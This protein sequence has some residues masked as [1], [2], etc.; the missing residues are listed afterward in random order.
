M[1]IVMI[2]CVVSIT[3]YL[4][5]NLSNTSI[6]NYIINH[7]HRPHRKTHGGSSYSRTTLYTWDKLAR[8]T[9]NNITLQ[10]LDVASG[11]IIASFH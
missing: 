5:V 6:S 7:H 2:R 9:E 4:S 11:C 3:V 8:K 10:Y 1:V